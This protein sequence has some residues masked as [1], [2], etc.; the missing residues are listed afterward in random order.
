MS[1]RQQWF[2][3]VVA[4]GAVGPAFDLLDVIFTDD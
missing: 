4:S 3:S 1:L 2:N